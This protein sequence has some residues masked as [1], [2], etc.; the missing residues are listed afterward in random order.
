MSRRSLDIMHI[1]QTEKER[2]AETSSLSLWLVPE[3]ESFSGIVDLND[4]PKPQGGAFHV[5][6]EMAVYVRQDSRQGL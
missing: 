3:P 4:S 5:L 2:K 6:V 1:L